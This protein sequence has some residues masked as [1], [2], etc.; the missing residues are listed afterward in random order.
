[1]PPRSRRS[2][3]RRSLPLR[4]A[5]AAGFR[6]AEPCPPAGLRGTSSGRNAASR[7]AT[8]CPA[9]GPP[10]PSPS[11][12][13]HPSPRGRGPSSPRSPRRS[14]RGAAT[15]RSVVPPGRAG[16]GLRAGGSRAGPGARPRRACTGLSCPLAGKGSGA[17]P[18][19]PRRPAAPP[20]PARLRLRPA[21]GT[22]CQGTPPVPPPSRALPG[23]S[24][25]GG[26]RGP[27]VR[28]SPRRAPR[29]GTAVR[30][31]PQRPAQ[32]CA[33]AASCSFPDPHQ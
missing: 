23:G 29:R 1:M 8:P 7:D 26:R 10:S 18:Q 30:R 33:T 3:P 25:G 21:P 11:P 12:R 15:P 19:C 32:C 28:R 17:A 20:R 16:K 5:P 22:P 13:T 9:Q 14:P 31:W 24:G 27:C 6:A 4:P 2:P